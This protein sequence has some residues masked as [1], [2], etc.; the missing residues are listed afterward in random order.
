[1]DWII[2]R[3]L[4]ADR[5]GF[6]KYIRE[7]YRSRDGFTSFLPDWIDEYD[8]LY[9]RFKAGETG[10]TGDKVKHLYWAC[11]NYWLFGGDGAAAA[12]EDALWREVMN[13]E[14][15]LMEKAVRFVPEESEG[16]E[17]NA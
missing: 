13:T 9:A 16:E 14:D 6:G 8:A 2:R 15:E 7:Q 10:E 1:M 3:C 4:E 11:L 12:W 5:E 17:G